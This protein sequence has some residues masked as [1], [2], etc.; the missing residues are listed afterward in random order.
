MRWG[1]HYTRV[2]GGRALAVCAVVVAFAA[3]VPTA[4]ASRP[5]ETGVFDPVSFSGPSA[6][7]AFDRVRSAGAASARI[8]LNWAGV[9]PAG[10]RK[11]VGFDAADP[12][13]PRYSW[14][15]ADA[16]IR[17]ATARGVS[18]ILVIVSAP[19]W[20]EGAGNG[21]AGT[22]RPDPTELRRFAAA[23]ARRYSGSFEDLPRVRRWQ[24]WNEPNLHLFLNPQF[25]GRTPVSPGWYRRMVNEMAAAVKGV[26]SDNVVVAGGTA[27]FRDLGVRHTNW[28]PLGFMRE[29]LCLDRQLRRKCAA[30]VRFDV[31]AHHPYTSG[32]PTRKAVLADDVS[33][34][35]LPEM[36]RVLEAGYRAGRIVSPRLP[37][38]W[39]TE[40]SWD[41]S[42]PDPKGVP[43]ALH[44]RWTAEALFRMWQNGVTLVTWFLLRDQPLA[45]SFYQSG[46]YFRG[47][48]LQADR[49]KPSLQ[50]FRF[51]LVAFPERGRIYVWGR[52]PA[53]KPGRVVIEQSFRGGWK[54]LGVVQ[55]DRHG[56][57]QRRFGTGTTGFVRARV[58]ET[59]VRARP[60]S[61]ARVPDRT[62]HPFGGTSLEPG[63]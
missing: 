56:I 13:D 23:A 52:T 36:R 41:S 63:R 20:A 7:L 29:L 60:F 30:R 24:V 12:A 2:V 35:D 11:P 1:A 38:F 32:G 14:G 61:L 8:T 5:L 19:A 53:G 34:G 39:V 51:P 50:A 40:F 57:V 26:H 16:E 17:A 58:V 21:A 44:A 9:A 43:S 4:S 31:W 45:T 6:G 37:Q 47:A 59:G 28:G 42:P 46:L 25:S 3:A 49:P 27:P 33:L 22:N 62:F 18:P 15:A 10:A 55:A 54:R 48:T